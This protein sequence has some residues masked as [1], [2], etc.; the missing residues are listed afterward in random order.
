ME[1]DRENEFPEAVERQI[2]Q[3]NAIIDRLNRDPAAQPPAGN[4][5]ADDPDSPSADDSA[6][7]LASQSSSAGPATDRT[8]WKQKYSVLQGKYDAEVPRLHVDLREAN[9]AVRNLQE[10]VNTLQ[11]T[12]ASLQAVSDR[13]PTDPPPPA[14]SPEEIEQFGPDLIDVIERK[15]QEVADKIVAAR[16][17]KVETSVQQVQESVASTGKTVA[18][19]ARDRVY[20]Q[21]NLRVPEWATINKS[22]EFM[23]WLH[24]EDGL[25]GQMRGVTLRGMFERNDADGVVKIFKSFQ[26]E[27]AVGNS[28]PGSTAPNSDPANRLADPKPEPQQSLDDLVAPGAP[29]TGPADAPKESENGRIWTPKAITE[30]YTRKNEF[31]KTRPNDDLPDTMVAEERDLF[32]AQV[33]GRIRA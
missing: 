11:A 32:K 31:V 28:D 22:D 1:S 24:K 6:N 2:S 25:S 21:L 26:K 16:I 13:R 10:Q 12:V 14:V 5:S 23:A 27:H 19:S 29:K 3:A 7:P 8:D 20:E 18:K 4:P 30:F 17:G 15:A 33:E 9:G